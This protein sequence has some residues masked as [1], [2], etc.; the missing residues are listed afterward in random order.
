MKKNKFV[1]AILS[2]A[3]FATGCSRVSYEAQPLETIKAKPKEEERV[4]VLYKPLTKKE[5]LHYLDRNWQK[6]GVQPVQIAI[7]NH[8]D[9]PMRFSQEG[10]SLPTYDLETIKTHA[11]VNTQV[12]ALGIGAPSLTMVTLGLVGLA[13]APATFGLTGILLPIGVGGIGLKAAS[14]MVK[15]DRSLDQDYET[16]Y[17]HDG[18]VPPHAIVEGIIFIP[19]RQ[20]SQKFTMKFTDATKED[21]F[22]VDPKRLR[23]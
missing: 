6:K 22:L 17:L 4:S 14:N 11:H 21:S 1:I 9:N 5:C 12:K 13:F 7:E 20:F 10:I 8:T 16:K 2:L 19:R 23:G 15:S 3:L 18:V